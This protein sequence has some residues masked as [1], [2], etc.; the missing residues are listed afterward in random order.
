M[1]ACWISWSCDIFN[2]TSTISGAESIRRVFAPIAIPIRLRRLRRWSITT[3]GTAASRKSHRRSAWPFLVRASASPSR[4]TTAMGTSTFSSPTIPCPNSCSTTRATGR[5]RTRARPRQGLGIALA[6]YDRDGHI[7]LFIANDSMPEF[8]FHNKGDGTFEEKGLLSQ[9]AVDEDGRT[10]AGM[11]VDFDDFNNDGL[12]DLVVDNLA[13]QMY[14]VY[15]NA[16]D[17][18]FN[19]TTKTSGM[20]RITMLH[21]GWGLRLIDYDNDGW[22]DM[23][24]A[25]GH[26]LDTI[27]QT[28]PQL[29][30]REPMLLV[31]NT[32]HG[33]VDVS[34]ASGS[35]F[36]Q[37]WVGRGLAT[38]D[39]DNDGR[40]DAVVSTNDGPA[41]VIHNETKTENHWLTLKLV[42]HKSNRDAIG[43]VVKLVTSQ[44]QQY[45]TVTTA[46]SYL[47]SSDKR[48]HFG[49]GPAVTAQTLEIL[50]PSGI[51][52][53]L[54]DVHAGQILQVD[55]PAPP[56]SP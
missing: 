49:L 36:H 38:G 50:W 52:Q 20:G 3:M 40:I 56:G 31:R 34:A 22:K 16:G 54:K 37:A 19:Y 4:I 25:Q 55:E 39:L 12:P 28:N 23:L 46:S 26:D 17:G 2:G 1:T 27:E 45:A 47:S 32:G 15:Q 21:S 30:Y 35:V 11:G 9:V 33:F 5:S 8:L 43:A 42:G 48:V 41:Y 7:D 14:A 29:R 13:D 44:G 6:D 53:V 51:R 18:T 10:Y 24:F